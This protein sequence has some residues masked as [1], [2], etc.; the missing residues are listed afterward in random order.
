MR[1]NVISTKYFTLLTFITL[2]LSLPW[3][4]LIITAPRLA[5]ADSP[6]APPVYTYTIVNTYPHDPQAFT[7]GLVYLDGIFYEGTGLRGRSSLRKV[8]PETGEVLQQINLPDQYFGEG[9]VVWQDKIVQLTWQSGTGFVYDKESFELRQSFTY[10]TEGWGITHDGERLIMS[11]GSANLYFWHPET[12]AEL[13]RVEVHDQHGPVV[14]LNEL[15]Y[16]NGEVYANI[17][18]TN[19]IARIDP[20]SG[21]VVGWIELSGLLTLPE[22]YSQ[23]LDVLNGIA[24]DPMT[25][26]LFVTGKLW[27]SLFEIKL[28]GP[29]EPDLVD[30]LVAYYPFSGTII[31]QSEQN[32]LVT[33]YGDAAFTVDRFGNPN[34]AYQLDGTDDYLE[35]PDADS[36]DMVSELTLV[37]WLY[38]EP[39]AETNSH[40]T[41]LEKSDPANGQARYGLWLIGNQ[42]EFCVE[43]A[44]GT[45]QRCLDSTVSLEV[46]RWHYLVGQYDGT[47]STLY[48]D[49]K[50]TGKRTDAQS[51]I[52][53]NETQIFI[54]ADPYQSTV[55][56]TQGAIDDVRIYNR[57]ISQVEIEALHQQIKTYLPIIIK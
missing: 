17:W 26:R 21:Y 54:G 56:F 33:P 57:I 27:P 13:G 25:D 35:I 4:S 52:A 49:G 1:N 23:P 51:A 39:Q 24:Y 15:E 38:Y 41:I 46:G 43:P 28:N 42:V 16:I 6:P 9:I 11:D 22:G 31:D 37:A 3:L 45:G 12:L 44:I 34:N 40:Y 14:R 18:Q 30:G 48:I 29:P 7:Q 32:H 47:Q 19:R 50:L 36:L 53:K 20:E 5:L 55:L 2:T 10:P 8:V